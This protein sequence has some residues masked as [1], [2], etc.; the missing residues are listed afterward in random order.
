MIVGTFGNI[1]F[2]VSAHRLYLISGFSRKS[3]AKVEEHEVAGGKPLSEFIAPK[4]AE[5]DLDITLL[6]SH[7]VNPVQEV[8][9]LREICETGQVHRLIIAG[10]N[11]GN[12]LLTEV[13]DDWERGLANGWP[14]VI[15]VKAKFKE[16]F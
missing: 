9:K 2:T 7:G 15:K 10:R 6:A 14:T 1:F 13:D 8:Y 5:I 16:Y 3:G 12:Y 11:M 4:L